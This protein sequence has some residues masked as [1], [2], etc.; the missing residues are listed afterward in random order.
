M[1]RL[2]FWFA[3]ACIGSWALMHIILNNSS[4]ISSITGRSSIKELAFVNRQFHDIAYASKSPAQKLD[5]YLPNAGEA[6]FPVI[7]FIHGGGFYEGSRESQE[8][9]APIEG[10]RRGYAVVSVDYRLSGQ[11]KFPAAVQDVNAALR[12]IKANA[13][14]FGLD[15]KRIALWGNSAGG[16]IAALIG[17]A[18]GEKSL[19]DLS[20]GHDKEDS[21]VQAVI[22]WSGAIDFGTMDEQFK[23]RGIASATIG[24]ANSWAS[25]YLGAAVATAQDKVAASNPETYIKSGDENTTLAFLIEH[26][27]NDDVVPFAQSQVFAQKLKSMLNGDKLKFVALNGAKHLDESFLTKANLDLVFDFLNTALKRRT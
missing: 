1:S 26:G 6:P 5:I 3:L 16:N 23:S 4:L 8:I 12:F 24:D 27:T 21:T 25:R 7:V 10:V 17:L 2:I 18:P 22:D 20:L 11:A 19:T 15:P 13:A 14:G 9:V